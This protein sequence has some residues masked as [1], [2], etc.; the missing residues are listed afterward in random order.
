MCAKLTTPAVMLATVLAIASAGSSLWNRFPLYRP[1]RF[2]GEVSY[3]KVSP[4]DGGGPP[5]AKNSWFGYS[6]S[7]LG[8]LNEDGVEDLLVTSV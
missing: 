3:I 1:G 7:R 2:G 4:D 5:M 6:I 8:D